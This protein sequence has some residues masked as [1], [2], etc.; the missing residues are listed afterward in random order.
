MSYSEIEETTASFPTFGQICNSFPTFITNALSFLNTRNLFYHPVQHR[1][2]VFLGTFYNTVLKHV[3]LST[4]VALAT[5]LNLAKTKI[6]F[7]LDKPLQ[8]LPDKEIQLKSTGLRC[9]LRG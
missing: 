6:N 4:F 1:S 9:K 7:A 8:N 5:I 2:Q 3:V